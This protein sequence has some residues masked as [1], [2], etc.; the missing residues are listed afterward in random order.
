M[1]EIRKYASA[2]LGLFAILLVYFAAF[3]N[4]RILMD[5]ND[6][7]ERGTVLRAYIYKHRQ[8]TIRRDS[9][10]YPNGPFNLQ[11]YRSFEHSRRRRCM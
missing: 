10:K 9:R 11:I 6:I 3:H 4:G 8:I 1:L 7:T 2:S 5:G